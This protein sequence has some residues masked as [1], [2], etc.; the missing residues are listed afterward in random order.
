[1]L[2]IFDMQPWTALEPRD[3]RRL[4]IWVVFVKSQGEVIKEESDLM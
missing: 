3:I 1:M 4:S 2:G